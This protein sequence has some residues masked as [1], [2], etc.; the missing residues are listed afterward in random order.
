MDLNAGKKPK[1]N[2]VIEKI[3]QYIDEHKMVPGMLF[4][5]ERELVDNCGVS[6]NVLREAFHV[7]EVRGILVSRQG[8]G[9]VLRHLPSETANGAGE[10]IAMS[11]KISL[12]TLIDM[13]EV[14]QALEV[15]SVELA[16]R[17]ATPKKIDELSSFYHDICSGF[18]RN[19]NTTGEFDLHFK[20]LELADNAYLE[21][22]VRR[23]IAAQDEMLDQFEDVLSQHT[24]EAYV[25]DHGN[26][27]R[28]FTE[29]N[30]DE[31]CREM[32]RHIQATIDILR[33]KKL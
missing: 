19:R 23:L 32:H 8:S 9:R 2:E 1:Y 10:V 20:Y 33:A 24:I 25:R 6:R 28:A 3:Y 16:V 4:P 31:A 29:R 17:K 5:P 13:Y 21:G 22:E 12:Y 15:K 27:V 7:L 30:A 18:F 26:I 14:R 11:G